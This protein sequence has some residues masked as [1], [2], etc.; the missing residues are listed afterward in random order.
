MRQFHGKIIHYAAA[1]FRGSF[2]SRLPPDR[3][4]RRNASSLPRRLRFFVLRRVGV[5]SILPRVVRDGTWLLLFG[6][7]IATVPGRNFVRVFSIISTPM[8]NCCAPAARAVTFPSALRADV[9][10][11][12]TPCYKVRSNSRILTFRVSRKRSGCSTVSLVDDSPSITTRARRNSQSGKF[13]IC[14]FVQQSCKHARRYI[15]VT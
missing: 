11:N 13:E 12:R 2:V 7:I 3:S 10:T 5:S 15:H 1:L 8:S 9:A 4:V 14:I 6:C